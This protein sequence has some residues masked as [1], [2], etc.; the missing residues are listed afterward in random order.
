M[1]M[2]DEMGRMREIVFAA[3]LI[4]SGLGQSTTHARVEYVPVTFRIAFEQTDVRYSSCSVV[5]PIRSNAAVTLR[6]ALRHHGCHLYNYR[7][8]YDELFRKHYVFCL[9]ALCDYSLP[10]SFWYQGDPASPPGSSDLPG[11]Y[12]EDFRAARGAILTFTFYTQPCVYTPGSY[13]CA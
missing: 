13:V 5:V 1:R 7:L 9:D 4:T 3:A 11:G 12:I 2:E 8:A 10:G 6:A